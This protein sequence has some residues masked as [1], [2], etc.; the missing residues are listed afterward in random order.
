MWAQA[1][2]AADRCGRCRRALRSLDENEPCV[3]CG[4]PLCATCRDG[5][6]FCWHAGAAEWQVRMETAMTSEERAHVLAI[7]APIADRQAR[8]GGH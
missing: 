3:I 7:L 1:S 2:D 8:R 5:Y 4:L 6:G